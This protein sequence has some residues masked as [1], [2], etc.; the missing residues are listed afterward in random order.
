VR[1]GAHAPLWALQEALWGLASAVRHSGV[2]VDW[3]G[4][5]AGSAPSSSSNVA[6]GIVEMP[7]AGST[8]TSGAGCALG[9]PWGT[10]RRL[11]GLF[12]LENGLRRRFRPRTPSGAWP[13]NQAHRPAAPFQAPLG[14]LPRLA[15]G[16]RLIKLRPLDGPGRRG[17]RSLTGARPRRR[18]RARA[19]A[20]AHARGLMALTQ[21]FRPHARA[22]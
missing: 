15:P 6:S 16:G 18:A 17:D 10:G 9:A 4:L 3:T 11:C 1:Q 20:E 2:G 21:T 7:V 12:R 13:P 8:A 19:A 22:S 14:R 5:G